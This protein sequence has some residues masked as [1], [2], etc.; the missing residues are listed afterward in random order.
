VSPRYLHLFRRQSDMA[1]IEAAAGKEVGPE[2]Q[3]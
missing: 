2:A 3:S 1:D